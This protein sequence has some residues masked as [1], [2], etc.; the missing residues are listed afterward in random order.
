MASGAKTTTRITHLKCEEC[1][2]LAPIHRKT[3]KTK[4]KNHIKHMYCPTCK[5]TKGFIELGE[6][7][8][9]PSWISEFQSQF[10]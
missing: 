10:D 1:A 8:F 9:I 7:A 2:Y 3:H 6:E 5:E 4:K